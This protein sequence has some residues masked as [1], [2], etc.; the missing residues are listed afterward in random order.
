LP[1]IS[2]IAAHKTSDF[3]IFP[4]VLCAAMGK[5]SIYVNLANTASIA[6]ICVPF[7]QIQKLILLNK[8]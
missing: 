8:M 2:P 3:V 4:G 1:A 5:I 6:K 7:I